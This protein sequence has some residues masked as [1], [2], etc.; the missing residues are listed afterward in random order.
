MLINKVP[1]QIGYNGNETT[2]GYHKSLN[3]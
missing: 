1:S 3:N 2:T